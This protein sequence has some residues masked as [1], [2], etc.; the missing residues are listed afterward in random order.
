MR[1][2][3][4]EDLVRQI[5]AEFNAGRLEQAVSLCE[6]GLRRS[7]NDP[8]LNHLFAAV[9][10]AKGDAARADIHI[11]AS[12]AARADNAPAHLLAGRI[13]R[14]S[15]AF[16]RAMRHLGRA[17]A[18]SPSLEILIEQ[19]RTLDA[20]GDRS[21]AAEA[22]RVVNHT[23]PALP[24]AAARLGRLLFEDGL[25]RDAATALEAVPATARTAS[26]WFDLALVKQ[27]L[28]DLSGAA[29]AYRKVLDLQ[30]DNAQA[31]VNLGI[32]LQDM[33]DIDG[34]VAA[35]RTAY[36]A[37]PETFGVIAMSLTSAPQGQL[38]LDREALKRMLKS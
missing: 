15:G 19:A 34:A 1:V 8:V 31:A 3:T 9:L 38:W 13:A 20:A 37:Q 10:F 17:A 30:P 2:A 6:T 5:V 26:L 36:G 21:R 11:Q 24:E 35:Y 12:L 29:E 4:T 18:V 22:W 23:N 33:H 16:D 28:R 7:R 14:S 32:V 25:L 27:D